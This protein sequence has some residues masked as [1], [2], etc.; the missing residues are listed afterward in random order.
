[1][2]DIK[3]LK[4]RP[5]F[6]KTA[7]QNKNNPVDQI[8]DEAILIYEEYLQ[9]LQV[10][11]KLRED[12]NVATKKIATAAN[13][14]ER[15]QMKLQAKVISEKIKLL[16][17]KTSEQKQILQAKLSFIPNP[18][19]A[20]VPISASEEDNVVIKTIADEKRRFDLKPHWDLLDEKQLVLSKQS[21]FQAGSRNVIYQD[22]AAQLTK[23]IEALMLKTHTEKGYLLYDAPIL[24]N[25]EL[26]FNT[27]QLPKM[28]EDLYKLENGQ[29]LIP[30]AEVTLTNLVA[31]QILEE[32]QLP[33]KFVASSLCFRKEAGAAGR[34]T[35]GI[36]RLHQFRKVELVKIVAQQNG[37]QELDSMLKDAA[38]I[39]D[40]LELPYRIVQLVS[41]DLSFGSKITYD[42]EVWM[43]SINNYREISSVSLMGDFQARRMQTKYR[44]EKEK[45][46]VY[47]LNGSGLAIDRTFAAILENY[48]QDDGTIEIPTA[49]KPYLG[50][51][52]I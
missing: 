48:Q 31:N 43:P 32:E 14:T 18:A 39:L 21:A 16:T 8:I 4:E 27:S 46:F 33:L 1:M 25:E 38:A 15:E 2:I 12:L 40:L 51:D 22:K 36:I 9:D 19:D 5:D 10:E 47:T 26:L 11:Q 34:D 35:R 24:V 52:K 42:L 23:A 20:S 41:G 7:A 28:Q 30:T 6:Y 3:D 17:K 45:H 37:M 13:E 29:Y 44:K 50:F 49:L